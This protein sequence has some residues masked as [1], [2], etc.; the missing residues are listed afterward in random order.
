MTTLR[1]VLLVASVY[2]SLFSTGVSK[3]FTVRALAWRSI[4]TKNTGQLT[5]PTVA[6]SIRLLAS[7][8]LAPCSRIDTLRSLSRPQ[9]CDFSLA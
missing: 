8:S 7:K 1:F 6:G 3:D 2:R 9:K 4:L 5:L